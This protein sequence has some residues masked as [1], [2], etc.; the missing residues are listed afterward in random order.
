MTTG[1][2]AGAGPSRRER[3]REATLR[4]IRQVARRLLVQEGPAAI[5]L[6]AIARE[7]GMTAPALYRY[8]PSHTEVLAALTSDLYDELTA[9]LE[10][11]RDAAPDAAT[12]SRLLTVCR[13]LRSWSLAHPAEFAMMFASPLPRLGTEPARAPRHEAGLRFGL[14]FYSLVLELWQARP[15]PTPDPAELDPRLL[16]QLVECAEAFGGQM[17]PEAVHVFL[18]CWVRLYG[19]VSME[20]F[21]QLHFA[22]HDVEPMFEECLR[23]LADLVG[24]EYTP[25]APE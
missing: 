13:T 14:V 11:A 24:V 4:E 1:T 20:Q 8:Y 12:G 3:L 15:Y 18:T 10:K 9:E 16:E 2:T 5:S 21:G 25:P 22:L 6:R 23:E 7:M 19:L 17:P